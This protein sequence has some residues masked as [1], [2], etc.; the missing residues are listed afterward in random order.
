MHDQDIAGLIDTFRVR[1]AYL[2]AEMFTQSAWFYD[3]IK[4]SAV[5][6]PFPYLRWRD[7][8]KLDQGAVE[9]TPFVGPLP[10]PSRPALSTYKDQL[11]GQ[12]TWR[13]GAFRRIRDHRDDQSHNRKRW[14]G[15]WPKGTPPPVAW[16]VSKTPSK[17]LKASIS[18]QKKLATEYVR[19]FIELN[20]LDATHQA[21]YDNLMI[22]M[23][24]LRQGQKCLAVLQDRQPWLDIPT[25]VRSTRPE[26][27]GAIQRYAR[28]LP[29]VPADTPAPAPK[30]RRR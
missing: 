15:S 21:L 24:A 17:S 29:N 25:M 28:K 6:I 19:K 10:C 12:L 27:S 4:Y 1:R 26:P 2:R 30:R 14:L 22:I 5:D 23:E 18:E 9:P 3:N 7:L 8:G 13:M 20:D 11:L 16:L